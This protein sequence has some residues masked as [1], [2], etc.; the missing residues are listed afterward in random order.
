MDSEKIDKPQ[1]LADSDLSDVSGGQ[2]YHIQDGKYYKYV[3]SSS[4][5]DW[6][7]SYLCPRCDEPLSYTGWGRYYCKDCDE[8]WWKEINLDLNLDSG[9][10]QEIS[11]EEYRKYAIIEVV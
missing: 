3:G 8:S 5:E 11:R 2:E 6:S 7:A 10:W 1:E 9:V 4:N